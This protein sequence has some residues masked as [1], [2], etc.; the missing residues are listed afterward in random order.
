MGQSSYLE[1]KFCS[2]EARLVAVRHCVLRGPRST[3]NITRMKEHLLVCMPYL[4]S[5]RAAAVKDDH[6]QQKVLRARAAPSGVGQS[7]MAS[8]KS[9]WKRKLIRVSG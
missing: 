7:I 2:R 6:L 4:L 1:D 8:S 5:D 3:S 9:S